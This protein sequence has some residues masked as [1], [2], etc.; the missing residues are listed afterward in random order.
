[1][2]IQGT[3]ARKFTITIDKGETLSSLVTK[4]NSEF[5]SNGTASISYGASGEGL[6]IAVNSG[7]TATLIA[8]PANF[9]VLARLGITAG[10]LANAST[11]STSTTSANSTSAT[12]VFGLGIASNMDI[13]TAT[14]AGAARAELLNVLSAIRS[15][16]QTTNTPAS[17]ASSSTS[18][19]SSG[20]ASPYLQS[21]VSSYTLALNMLSSS[22]TNSSSTASGSGDPILNI[23][24]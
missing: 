4:I 5:G 10:T 1:V 8:G 21:Q 24:G 2:Q 9:D 23:I 16:Y 20:T 13:S 3:A 7:V 12:N 17:S 22:S 18:S 6:K 11:S 15:A 14:G 19:Q